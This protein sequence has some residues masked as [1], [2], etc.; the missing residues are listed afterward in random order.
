MTSSGPSSGSP[1]ASRTWS[2][3][4]AKSR[5]RST[6]RSASS[7]TATTCS[8]SLTPNSGRSSRSRPRARASAR[9]SFDT[10]QQHGDHHA[11]LAAQDLKHGHP[12]A[13]RS[14][15]GLER[16]LRPQYEHAV[17]RREDVAAEEPRP[18]RKAAVPLQAHARDTSIKADGD[19]V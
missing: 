16:E 3:P 9:A 6:T 2:G 4:T 14:L 19:D 13:R 12:G 10:R 17:D 11:P 18:E 15:V 8:A 7:S 1:A 5:R